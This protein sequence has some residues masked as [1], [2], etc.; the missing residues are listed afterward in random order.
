MYLNVSQ[1]LKETSGSGR[2]LEIDDELVL[3]GDANPAT[4]VKGIVALLRTDKGIWVSATLESKMYCDCSRCLEP[5]GQEVQLQFEEEYLPIF[6]VDTGA[7]LVRDVEDGEQ[8][9]IDESNILDLAEAV[10]QYATLN[11]PMKPI[12]R[13]NCRGIC[14]NCGVNRNQTSC[15]CDDGLIDS[16]WGPLIGLVSTAD[17][18]N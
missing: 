4:R 17:R 9:F 10:R 12:C 13:N 11:L 15:S 2:T 6:D 1:L 16:R 18:T 14:S 3:S 8:F 7:R 5:Y